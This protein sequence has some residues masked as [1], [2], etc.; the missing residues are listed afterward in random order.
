MKRTAPAAVLCVLSCALSGC[1][2]TKE[3][4]K[5]KGTPGVPTARPARKPARTAPGMKPEP[6]AVP[7]GGAVRQSAAPLPRPPTTMW[8]REIRTCK[9]CAGS[10]QSK[11]CV[12]LLRP[13]KRKKIT[14]CGYVSKRGTTAWTA[15]EYRPGD[16]LHIQI[17]LWGP[18]G[19]RTGRACVKEPM[20]ADFKSFSKSGRYVVWGGGGGGFKATVAD[21][22]LGRCHSLSEM[23][24]APK[25]SPISDQLVFQE[26]PSSMTGSRSRSVLCFDAVSWKEHTLVRLPGGLATG[27]DDPDRAVK[28]SWH[29]NGR[30]LLKG[31]WKKGPRAGKGWNRSFNCPKGKAQPVPVTAKRTRKWRGCG[32]CRGGKLSRFPSDD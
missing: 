14:G 24:D 1:A 18:A 26:P 10:A 21:L 23:I 9:R 20:F 5:T 3:K 13:G 29:R 7:N 31:F 8:Y 32:P 25:W 6:R 12:A 22:S 2:K 19:R 30:V 27:E 28:A 15:G 4:E 17:E 11:N 16:D